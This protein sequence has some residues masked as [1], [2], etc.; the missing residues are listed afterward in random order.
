M[1]FNE[2]L[3]TAL[4]AYRATPH[5]STGHSPSFLVFGQDPRLAPDN[6]WRLEETPLNQERLK[7]LS[8][9]RLDVQ[10]Q[11]QR[12]S[13][14]INATRNEERQPTEFK[15]HQLVLC[16]LLPLDRLKYKSAF[17]KAVPRWT[18]PYR[19]LSVSPSLRVA[20]VKCLLTGSS[21]QVHI[22]DVRFVE[23]PDGEIQKKEW[24]KALSEEAF[25]I[26]QP[27]M[28][29]EVINRFFE[30]L[31]EPQLDSASSSTPQTHSSTPADM[32]IADH[33]TTN[34]PMKKRARTSI[35]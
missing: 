21:R 23:R 28:A 19:V 6:D 2:A 8:L 9:L 25:T 3:D 14:S 10:L 1:P 30:R 22:Q 13:I 17:Y 29:Q 27:G 7:F 31:A 34:L 4:R 20:V 33:S 5:H 35:D 12:Q 15:V 11:C 18:T 32:S 16:R 24:E 26:Y